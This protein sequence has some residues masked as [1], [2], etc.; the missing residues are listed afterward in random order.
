MVNSDFLHQLPELS[1]K[2]SFLGYEDILINNILIATGKEVEINVG[3]VEKVVITGDVLISA[4]KDNSLKSES[5]GCNQYSYNKDRRG[6]A[7]CRRIL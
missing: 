6:H 5:D 7:L 4:S 1:I 2:I 3:M